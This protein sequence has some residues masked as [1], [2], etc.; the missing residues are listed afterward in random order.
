MGLD[1][2]RAKLT[3]AQA[4]LND[5]AREVERFFHDHPIT[6]TVDSTAPGSYVLLV[7][8][9]PEIPG[10]RWALIIGDCVHNARCC[11]DYIAWELAG[12]DRGDRQTQ[13]P[14]YR[15][16]EGWLARGKKRV[17]RLKPEAQAFIERLQP[18][19]SPKPERDVLSGL[20]DL[21]DADKHKLLTVVAAKPEHLGVQWSVPGRP[22]VPPGMP[23]I[24][25]LPDNPLLPGNVIATVIVPG[26]VDGMDLDLVEFNPT[27]AFGPDVVFSQRVIVVESLQSIIDAVA[28]IAAAAEKRFFSS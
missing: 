3:R 8:S 25:I 24:T 10:H 21:D 16:R 11:L 2:A 1:G 9:A 26:P 23:Q 7:G 14:I 27:I 4:H 22:D 5:L 17:E 20:I 19:N 12:A 28:H 6:V 15:R 18:F 13:F